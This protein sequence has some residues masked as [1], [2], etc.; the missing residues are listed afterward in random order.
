MGKTRVSANLQDNIHVFQ[1]IYGAA[2]DI[3]MRT[4]FLGENGKCACFLAYQEVTLESEAWNDSEVGRLVA[5]LNAMP[6]SEIA[7]FLTEKGEE[8]SDQEPLSYVEDAAQAMLTGCAVVFVDGYDHALKIQDKGYPSMGVDDSDSEKS[9]R[10]SY[11]A[12]TD[13]VKVNAA[14][15]RKRVRSTRVRVWSMTQGV[16]S[17]SLVYLVY[18]EDLARPEVLAEI[19]R[20]LSCYEIDGVLDSGVLEQLSEEKW[21]SPF[22]QFQTTI[23]PDR[24]AMAILEGRIVLMVN[25]SP[26]ALILPT[27]WNSFLKTTDDYYVRFEEATFARVLRYFAAF[28]AM[29]LP[30]LYLA[31][32]NFHTQLLP[33]PLLISFWQERMGVPFPAVVEVLLMEAAFELLREAGVRLPGAMGNTIGIVGGLIIG[34]AAVDANLVRPIVV[35]VVAFTALCSFSVPN[36]E[37]A[38][39]FR[40]LKFF[41]IIMSAWL[42]FFGFLA[43][44][45]IVLI[46][47][48]KLQSFGIPYLMPFVA[49]D[50]NGY[51]DQRDFLWRFPLRKLTRRPIYAQEGERRKLRRSKDVFK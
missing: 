42:G 27:D 22:P 5:V 18:M 19:E 44:L 9:V 1:D 32:T 39:A 48:T 47:L 3:K 49:G 36:E 25:G 51:H 41:F 2:D 7:S 37:F 24:A 29:S 40:I 20:R 6:E 35:I 26:T 33:T 28:F 31:V 14:L 4:L 43:A 21:Y 16:R 30:G 34:S 15:I 38:F 17:H 11:E 46:H 12:F 45:T 10:G 23:R 50:L 8:F 13:S